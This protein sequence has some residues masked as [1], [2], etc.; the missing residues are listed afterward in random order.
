MNINDVWVERYRPQKLEDIALPADVAKYFEQVKN[1]QNLPNTLLVGPP[2]VGKTTCAKVAVNDLIKGQYLYINASD[3]N[4]IDTIRSKV[5]Q[6]AQTKSIFDS[7][8]VVILDEADGISLEGQ[9]A[10]RNSM[11]EF[12]E[13]TRFILTANFPHKIIPAVQSRC[14]V[15]ALR[16]PLPAFVKRVNDICKAEELDID[17]DSLQ[18]LCTTTYPDLRRAINHLQKFSLT[19]ATADT[20]EATTNIIE[21]CIKHVRAK[22][23]YKARKTV[24]TNETSFG[25]DY[26]TLFN[27]LFDYLFDNHMELSDEKNRDCMIAVS[28]YMY[29]NNI[30]V[31]KEINFYTCLLA[32]TQIL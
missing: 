24:I 14:N 16:P 27:V 12:S 17:T 28:E 8:K 4:G 19:G 2:G 15:I 9:K 1:T 13:I 31:D 29:R 3:E 6:F 7:T 21:E 25:G 20:R 32:L 10:L 11:E 26:D 22:D 23:M 5:I 30:V 18:Q